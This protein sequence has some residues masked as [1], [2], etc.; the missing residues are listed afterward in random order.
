MMYQNL[1]L[2]TAPDAA[3]AAM[4]IQ[5]LRAVAGVDDVGA[6]PGDGRIAVAFDDNRTSVL[7][8]ATVLARAGYALREP[9]KA[10]GNGGCCGGCGG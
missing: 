8:L 6:T 1:Q 9:Q 2:A 7:E 3:G 10:H 5:A 4:I